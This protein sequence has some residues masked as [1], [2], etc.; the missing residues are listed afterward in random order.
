[1]R[2]GQ[3][4]P[5]VCSFWRLYPTPGLEFAHFV[6]LFCL[7]KN[8][9][10]TRGNWQNFF[11]SLCARTHWIM[12]RPKIIVN[13]YTQKKKFLFSSS[14]AK[15][16]LGQ[17]VRHQ[18]GES[19]MNHYQKT[20]CPKR[21]MIVESLGAKFKDEIC[22]VEKPFNAKLLSDVWLCVI[23]N[24]SSKLVVIVNLMWSCF[25]GARES[26]WKIWLEG[27]L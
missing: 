6:L 23:F 3:C 8:A 24:F 16:N 9:T 25:Y 18:S 19:S 7:I 2:N 22:C 4:T 17:F 12:C 27:G 11:L 15:K 10:S 1:M 20:L 14:Q 26:D 5:L 21:V 13:K